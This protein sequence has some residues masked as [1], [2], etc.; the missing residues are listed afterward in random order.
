MYQKFE[1][2]R[3]YNYFSYHQFCSYKTGQTG[4]TNRSDQSALPA[5]STGQIG[6]TDRSDRSTQNRGAAHSILQCVTQQPRGLAPPPP[7]PLH[8]GG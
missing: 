3:S 5:D 6:S 7:T 8:P 1:Y 4:A 2:K